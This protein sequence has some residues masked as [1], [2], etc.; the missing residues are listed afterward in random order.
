[1]DRKKSIAVYTDGSCSP[2]HRIG[3]WAAILLIDDQKLVL[4]GKEPDTTHQRMELTAVLK[5]LEYCQHNHLLTQPVQLYADSQ[6]VINLE[7]R[8]AKLESNSYLTK[9]GQPIRNVDLVKK[10]IVYLD[11]S[12][13]E[14]IK[15]AAHQ[16]NGESVNINR[17][18]D[19]IARRIIREHLRQRSI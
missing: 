14:F 13:V 3:S 1:L 9:S 16:K 7:K 10:L 15:V 18:V 5:A 11:N 2:L 17:E 6:Y 12:V 19:K 8:R 4:K